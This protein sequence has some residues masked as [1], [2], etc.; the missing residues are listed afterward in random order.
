MFGIVFALS[1]TKNL[2][3]LPSR[4]PT[5]TPETDQGTRILN[6]KICNFASSNAR[7]LRFSLFGV[8]RYTN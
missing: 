6:T 1:T 5:E 7:D 3:N 4:G 2:G 8:F